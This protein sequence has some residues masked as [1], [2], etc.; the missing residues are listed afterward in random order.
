MASMRIYPPCPHCGAQRDS[1]GLS[2]AKKEMNGWANDG[3]IPVY[4][5]KCLHCGE[6]FLTFMSTLPAHA[7]LS[8]LDEGLRKQRREQKRKKYGYDPDSPFITRGAKRLDS[9]RIEATIRIRPGA[10]TKGLAKKLHT[11][12]QHRY[13]QYRNLTEEIA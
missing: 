13:A 6:H 3:E 4:Y 8:A 5:L 11:S 7:S 10:I 1:A 12:S 9:D 2:T